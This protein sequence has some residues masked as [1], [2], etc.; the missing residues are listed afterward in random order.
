MSLN[1]AMLALQGLQA[2]ATARQRRQLA[3]AAVAGLTGLAALLAGLLM[4]GW[5]LF[6]GFGTVLPAPWAAAAAAACLFLL[7]GLCATLALQ[8]RPRPANPLDEALGRIAPLVKQHPAAALLA[9]A[10]LG[11]LTGLSTRR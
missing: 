6:L 2:A 11:G 10:A 4:T 1:L 3:V 5:A 8:C 9:A 7:A